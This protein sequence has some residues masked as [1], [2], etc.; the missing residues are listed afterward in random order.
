MAEFELK[1]LKLVAYEV[2]WKLQQELFQKALEAKRNG[3]KVKNQVLFVEHPPVF[4]LGK[5][6]DKSNILASEAVLG[7]KI[8]RIER[9]G[10][11]TFHGPGQLVVYPIIDIEDFNMSLRNYVEN[12]EQVIINTLARFGLKGERSKGASGVWLDV[13]TDRERKISALGI[14]A[15]RHVTMHGLAFNINTDLTWFQKINPC[16]FTDKQVTSLAKELGEKQNFEEIGDIVKEEF[17][18][19]FK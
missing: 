4:T 19:I 5:S 1:Y 9:G 7:A 16:G 12:M 18:K 14:K 13:G 6:G 10:D 8:F 3:I 15:S 17:N 2:V 11:V